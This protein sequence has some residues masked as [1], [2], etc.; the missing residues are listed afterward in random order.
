MT[1]DEVLDAINDA[2]RRGLRPLVVIMPITP[3]ALLDGDERILDDF[4]AKEGTRAMRAAVATMRADL[5]RIP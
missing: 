5:R 4:V 2:H 1:I 3:E